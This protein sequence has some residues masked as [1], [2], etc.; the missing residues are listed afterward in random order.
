MADFPAG[1]AGLLQSQEE[2]RDFSGGEGDY[3]TAGSQQAQGV[4]VESAAD[5]GALGQDGDAGFLDGQAHAGGGG[6][7]AE[8]GYQAALGGVVEGVD[9]DG[10]ESDAGVR[11]YTYT[12]VGQESGGGVEGFGGKSG[13]EEGVAAF[14]GQEGGSFE[15]DA[16]GDDDAV[17][18]LGA[19]GGDGAVGSQ[20]AQHCS[21]KDGAVDAVGDFAVAADE[22]DVE[23]FA[24]LHQ[25]VKDGSG[26]GFGEGLGQQQGSQEPLGDAAGAG[27]VVGVDLDGVPAD[28]VGGEGDGVAGDDEAVVA[29]GEDSGV[30]ADFGAEEDLGVVDGGGV[31]ELG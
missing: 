2:G 1:N 9:G 7:F 24:G 12:G 11:Y 5:F 20:F 4:E 21:H 16:F 6:Y 8:A 28:G 25:L 3:Q 13:G 15:G 18:F 23:G 14:P 30:L 31:Q 27:D 17:A 22:G 10:V 26:G 29:E 19:A